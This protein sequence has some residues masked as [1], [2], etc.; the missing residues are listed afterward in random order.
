MFY[1]CSSLE[2]LDLSSFD[3]SKVTDMRSMFYGC[4]RLES[5]YVS[6]LFVSDKV[7]AWSYMFTNCDSLMGGS[8]TTYIDDSIE[9]AHIDG[10]VDNPGYFTGRRAKWEGDANGNNVLNAVDAQIAYEIATTDHYKNRSDY[11]NMYTRSD[12]THDGVVD[13]VDAFAIQRVALCG[14]DTF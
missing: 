5:V 6:R 3:T 1:G 8:G 4:S 2:S 11:A 13:A 7:A 12:V 14:W 9:Y 10:G